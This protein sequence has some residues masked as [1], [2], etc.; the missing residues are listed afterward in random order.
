M[1]IENGL[2]QA[3][4]GGSEPEEC[5]QHFYRNHR[6]LLR[7]VEVRK[8]VMGREL[9]TSMRLESLWEASRTTAPP[10]FITAIY[11]APTAS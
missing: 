9:T 2:R 8:G 11:A 5:T 7:I 10:L 1:T 6:L 4:L 3:R